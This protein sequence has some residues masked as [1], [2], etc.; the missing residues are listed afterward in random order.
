MT[1][2]AAS[3]LTEL[4]PGRFSGDLHIG[5]TI[6]GKPNGGYLLAMLGRAVTNV[7]PHPHVIAASA[8]YLAPP[9]PGPVEVHA[10]VLRAGRTASQLRAWMSQDGK[11]CVE[12]LLTTSTLPVRS[13]TFWDGGLP[14]APTAPFDECVRLPSMTP[15]GIPVALLDEVEVRMD[16]ATLGFGRGRPSGAGELRGWLN[17]PGESF[18]PVSL[19]FAVDAFPP[20]TFEVA[21]S[22]WVPTFELSVYVRA[23][24][25]PGPVRVLQKARLIESGRVDEACF[26]WDSAGRLVAQGTQLAG[27]RIVP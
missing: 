25:A 21:P 5:W 3:A 12:A 2:A 10:Q 16:E 18:D 6:G 23:L 4:A 15:T 22:G 24:A 14:S 8:H 20:G 9:Q 19:I 11:P 17:L 26:I 13:E 1:F 27:I 7:G